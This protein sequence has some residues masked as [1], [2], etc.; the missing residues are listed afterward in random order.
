M[1]KSNARRRPITWPLAIFVWAVACDEDRETALLDSSSGDGPGEAMTDS[2]AYPETSGTPAGGEDDAD[3]ADNLTAP[4]RPSEATPP[5][6]FPF[7]D[8]DTIA[9]GTRYVT[10][11][12]TTPPG[13]GDC[14]KPVWGA[15]YYVPYMVHGSG[16][17]ISFGVCTDAD[18]G[19][20][21]PAGPGA[22][23]EK[24]RGVWAPSVVYHG[25]RFILFYAASRKGSLSPQHPEGQ[26]CIGKAYAASARGPFVD[27]GEFACPPNGRWALDPDAFV[28]NGQ[29]YVV[30]RDDNVNGFPETGISVV[31]ADKNGVA[32]WATRRTLLYSTDLS[33]ESVGSA[34]RTIENPSM[35]KISNGRWYLFFSGNDWNSRRYATGIADCGTSPLP[36]ARC[37]QTQGSDHSY[38]GYQP[39]ATAPERGLPLNKMG[40]GGMSLFRTFGGQARVVWHYIDS[41]SP[42]PTRHSIIGELAFTNGEWS[43]K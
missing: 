32:N 36:A 9:T 12:T 35:M 11:G 39:S 42:S 18:S 33:W 14:G 20:A 1:D 24:S 22:W 7:A 16:E 21:M 19:D 34:A 28:D 41:E 10:Y 15:K 2:E 37:S 29:L 40:P 43:V 27:A 26:K 31:A 17:A 4:P 13:V 6:A 30:Y 23:A 25:G 8:P 5:S 3:D 38:F